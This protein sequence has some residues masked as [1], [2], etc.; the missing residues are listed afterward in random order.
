MVGQI[1]D[2]KSRWENIFI[3][4]LNYANSYE[5]YVNKYT[6]FPDNCMTWPLSQVS[7]YARPQRKRIEE[8]NKVKNCV[9]ECTGR[10]VYTWLTIFGALTMVRR[11]P[12]NSFPAIFRLSAHYVNSRTTSVCL[13][14]FDRSAKVAL[15]RVFV[16]PLFFG[17]S[18]LLLTILPY[19]FSGYV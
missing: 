6:H 8:E 18:H 16:W 7:Q 10:N 14:N 17:K 4:Q 3:V 11:L 5:K 1:L 9:N 15:K 2:F 12:P 13:W 19:I